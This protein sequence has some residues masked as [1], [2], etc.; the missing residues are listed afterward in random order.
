MAHT[1]LPGLFRRL[2]KQ[3]G[4][5]YHLISSHIMYCMSI[6]SLEETCRTF[7]AQRCCSCQISHRPFCPLALVEVLLIF[8]TGRGMPGMWSDD[9]T[10]CAGLATSV[11]P[12]DPVFFPPAFYR[13][14]RNEQCHKCNM[15]CSLH[16][17][18]EQL[19][20]VRHRP[21]VQC[22][23]VSKI[24]IE[25]IKRPPSLQECKDERDS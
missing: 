9:G 25:I 11:A 14:R 16:D 5:P 13:S 20:E 22:K 10:G 6:N 12:S 17:V 2:R 18:D 23:T 4:S 3:P 8:L 19:P 1:V 24:T 21:Q 15:T 7:F